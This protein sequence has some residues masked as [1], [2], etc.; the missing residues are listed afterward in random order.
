MVKGAVGVRLAR[1]CEQ[2]SPAGAVR[3]RLDGRSKSK[4]NHGYSIR[5][6]HCGL[7]ATGPH[8]EGSSG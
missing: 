6:P 5:L 1:A 4:G 8:S 2:G 3:I 7:A